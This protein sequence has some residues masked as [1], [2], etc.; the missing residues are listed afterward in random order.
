MKL[1]I[2]LG[3][4]G[5]SCPLLRMSATV[6]IIHN[7]CPNRNFSLSSLTVLFSSPT[8]FTPISLHLTAASPTP[9]ASISFDIGD[10]PCA[11]LCV[12]RYWFLIQRF[13]TSAFFQHREWAWTAKRFLYIRSLRIMWAKD[14]GEICSYCLANPDFNV[15]VVWSVDSIIKFSLSSLLAT[16]Y[17]NKRENHLSHIFEHLWK[18]RHILQDASYL[19]FGANS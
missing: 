14:W 9:S 10:E 3:L 11:F 19:Y 15:I 16:M 5:P 8:S 1:L 4:V 18:P 6:D 7:C 12:I 2:Y 13:Y 17:P